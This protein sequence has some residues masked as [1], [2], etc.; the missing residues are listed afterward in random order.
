MAQLKRSIMEVTAEEKFLAHALVFAVPNITNDYNY[1]SYI[2]GRTNIFPNVGELLQASCV[3][4]S[5]V[6][7]SRNFRS[8]SAMCHSIY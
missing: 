3:F 6:G 4:L 2:K 1:L 7:G 5:G 8:F